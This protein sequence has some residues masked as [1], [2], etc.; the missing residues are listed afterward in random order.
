MNRKFGLVFLNQPNKFADNSVLPTTSAT[1]AILIPIGNLDYHALLGAVASVIGFIGY[2]PYYRDV[3]RRKTNPHPFTYGI[4][5]LLSA[6]TFAA[7]LAKGAGPGAWVTAVPVIMGL[8][9]VILTL[10]YGGKREIVRIDWIL[11]AAAL[12]A[13]V[14]WRLTSDPLYAVLISTFAS[15]CAFV[16]TFRKSYHK[17]DEETALS[18]ALGALRSF[19]AIPALLSFNITTLLPLL[20]NIAANVS[21]VTMVLIRRRSKLKNVNN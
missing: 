18:Y 8:G 12:C 4:W 16:P 17:P 2:V 7:Q 15:A 19:V 10:N 1:F 9:V 13:I 20:E 3:L 5:A 21:F 11:L 6:I 14:A